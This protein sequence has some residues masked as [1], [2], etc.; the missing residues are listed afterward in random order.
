MELLKKKIVNVFGNNN[1]LLGE[2]EDGI[3]YYLEEAHFDCGWYWGI[4]YIETFTNNRQPT[5]SVDI[6]SHEHFNCK[7]MRGGYVDGYEKFFKKSVLNRHEI[8][9]LFELMECAYTLSKM[10]GICECRPDRVN[11]G[12]CYDYLKNQSEY[13]NIIKVKLPAVLADIY[14]LLGGNLTKE[15]FG[16][17][18][19]YKGE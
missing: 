11:D 16:K 4:G 3:R 1:Y 6:M 8:Y 2:D 17:Q 19:I 7:F 14:N 5:R 12:T 15:Y 9:K 13:L 10:A 18:A